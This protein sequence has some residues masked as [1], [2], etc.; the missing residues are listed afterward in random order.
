MISRAYGSSF[1]DDDNE[2]TDLC[3]KRRWTVGKR[4]L[5]SCFLERGSITSLDAAT[6]YKLHATIFRCGMGMDFMLGINA[7]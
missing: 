1:Y 4:L 7:F 2:R 3:V 5:T 6:A